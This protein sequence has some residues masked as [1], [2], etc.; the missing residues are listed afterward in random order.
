MLKNLFVVLFFVRIKLDF[1]KV[2]MQYAIRVCVCVRVW[3]CKLLSTQIFIDLIY[4]QTL[5]HMQ[6]FVLFSMLLFL[7]LLY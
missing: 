1:I 2:R 4:T 7:F 6:I 5:T 3:A